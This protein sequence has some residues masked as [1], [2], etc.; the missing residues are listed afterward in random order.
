MGK[1][2]DPREHRVEY[3][4][5]KLMQVLGLFTQKYLVF[6]VCDVTGSC[7][8]APPT[9][10]LL[11]CR[12]LHYL[13][14]HVPADKSVVQSETFAILFHNFDSQTVTLENNRINSH[15]IWDFKN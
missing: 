13:I 9:V 12:S 15:K 4:T 6:S 7:P 11:P 10:V 5:C 14:G 3:A 1:L 2:P 8:S